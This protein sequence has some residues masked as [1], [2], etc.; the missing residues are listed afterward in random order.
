MT[1]L[2][3]Q[4]T[5]PVT[6]NVTLGDY[7]GLARLAEHRGFDT[8]A[9]FLENLLRRLSIAGP[10]AD[11]VELLVRAGLT[12]AQISTELHLMLETVRARRRRLG[13]PVNP[14]YRKASR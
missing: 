6:V 11:E 12:D 2:A 3:R 9:E 5:I 7:P 8:I 1:R 14:Q 4:H 10:G 13:L